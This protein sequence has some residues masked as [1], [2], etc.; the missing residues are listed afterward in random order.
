MHTS[1]RIRSTQHN[2]L[3]LSK[4]RIYALQII[5]LLIALLVIGKLFYW[6]ILQHETLA[7]QARSQHLVRLT[8]AASR[9]RILAENGSV[10]ATNMLTYQV[11]VVPS[12]IPPEQR[13]DFAEEVAP[14]VEHNKENL[15]RLL[16]SEQRYVVLEHRMEKDS[17]EKLLEKKEIREYLFA[18][19]MESRFY[20]EGEVTGHITGYVDLQQEGQYSME[21]YFNGL[22]S[23]KEGLEHYEADLKNNP[24]PLGS[25]NVVAP[26]EGATIITTI[27]L[28]LQQKLYEVLKEAVEDYGAS[29]GLIVIMNPFTGEIPA[30][31]SYPTYDPNTYSAYVDDESFAIFKNPCIEQFEPGSIFKII[32]TAAGIDSEVI[33][34]YTPFYDT[35]KFVIDGKTIHNAG[36]ARYG[37][38]DTSI[39]LEK[40]L[41]TVFAD[42]AYNKLGREVFDKYIRSFGFGKK[43]DIGLAG[44]DEGIVYR[45]ERLANIDVA[46]MGF[47]QAIA[48]TPIQMVTAT[49]ALVNGG[50]LY[51][52]MLIK[53]IIRGDEENIELPRLKERILRTTTT[54][55]LQEMLV[56]VVRDGYGKDAGIA[57][58]TTAGKT[59]TA[60]K[61]SPDGGYEE[62]K[63]VASFIGYAPA[64][65][66]QF[67][68]LVSL[69][70]DENI[71]A[72]M[73][74]ASETAEPTFSKAGKIVLQRL[75]VPPQ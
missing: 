59:G 45:P 5:G 66:P 7:E 48:V 71:S 70:L 55:D 8:T 31:V 43:T 23:G 63:V 16:S 32:T 12:D 73:R 17:F 30:M 9:G 2:D 27:D 21:Q 40:S 56:Q 19:E 20:P 1:P 28:F 3:A 72:S 10:L 26:E 42:I 47:G 44:E 14:F 4:Y 57:G 34:R 46:S 58:Y 18:T 15:L 62:N 37:T 29:K 39:A 24:I 6:Q 69:H 52:P 68:M 64:E 60:Q 13:E 36:R 22:L 41:N 25:R 53:S 74:W 51:K 11:A 75:G 67:V 54:E 49:S 33:T 38:V 61:A 65:D 35:G 50:Y